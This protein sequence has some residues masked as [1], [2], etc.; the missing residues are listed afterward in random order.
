MPHVTSPL[1]GKADDR[2]HVTLPYAAPWAQAYW[3]LDQN[4]VPLMVHFE[5]YSKAPNE[6]LC[7]AGHTASLNMTSSERAYALYPKLTFQE[8]TSYRPWLT[9]RDNSCDWYWSQERH[10]C[11]TGKIIEAEGLKNTRYVHISEFNWETGK[12]I[13]PDGHVHDDACSGQICRIG[14][15]ATWVLDLCTDGVEGP[16]G[17]TSSALETM[18]LKIVRNLNK[19]FGD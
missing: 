8:K 19:D 6:G 11:D 12:Y 17:L 7:E 13:L 16:Q 1:A 5:L 14:D 2:D 4:C 3:K 9:E 15:R 18:T 10:Q